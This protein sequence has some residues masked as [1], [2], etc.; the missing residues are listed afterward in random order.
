MGRKSLAVE[1]TNQI[2]D[3]FEQCIVAYGFEGATLQRTADRASMNLGMIHHYIG[4]KNELLDAMVARLIKRTKEE[5]VSFNKSVP[6]S[7]RLPFLIALFFDDDLDEFD[8]VID[9]LYASGYENPTIKAALD[10][11]NQLYASILKA[12]VQRIH[13]DLS[14]ERCYEIALT[15]LGLAYGSGALPLDGIRPEIW[16]MSAETLINS[17]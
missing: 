10:N 4:R 9:A 15:V 13:P 12:E 3:A 7:E 5:M 16:R 17:P 11:I 8:K 14:A 2:L 6:T 1:R